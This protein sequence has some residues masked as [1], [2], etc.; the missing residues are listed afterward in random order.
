MVFT[1]GKVKLTSKSFLRKIERERERET[2]EQSGKPQV[3][4]R[5][6]R[7]QRAGALWRNGGREVENK[8]Y[9]MH[10]AA[11]SLSLAKDTTTHT[12]TWGH[13]I[14]L[15]LLP[16]FDA[17]VPFVAKLASGDALAA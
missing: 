14:R 7:Q 4:F 3:D 10:A 11:L 15:K 8:Y 13:R 1:L 6:R 17:V 12:Y 2:L 5:L 16:P 9:S